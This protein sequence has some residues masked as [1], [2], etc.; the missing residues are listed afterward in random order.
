MELHEKPPWQ[1]EEEHRHTS[2]SSTNSSGTLSSTDT[3]LEMGP[4]SLSAA[5]SSSQTLP[6][7][8]SSSSMSMDS[9]QSRHS[10]TPTSSHDQSNFLVGHNMQLPQRPPP[11]HGSPSGSSQSP[12]AAAA[13]F[14][15]PRLE[16]SAQ[17]SMPP[18]A[19]VV[20][21]VTGKA[22]PGVVFQPSGKT[23]IV[24]SAGKDA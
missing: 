12:V 19:Q 11:S 17:I 10:T 24:H 3:S 13:C 16:P 14:A 2:L 6:S 23:N 9:S 5:L 22:V 21:P 8:S 15:Q 4:R 1:R 7:P 18:K 20:F